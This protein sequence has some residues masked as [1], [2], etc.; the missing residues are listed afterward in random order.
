MRISKIILFF[1]SIVCM[2]FVASENYELKYPS[3]FPKPVYNFKNNE[4]TQSKI[5]LGRALFYDN[6]LSKNN[7][8]SCASCHSNYNAFSH[9]DHTLSHGIYDSIGKR[10]A[11]ALMNLAW[12]KNFMWDGAINHLDMQALAPL[13]SKIEMD[14]NINDVITKLSNS[15]IYPSLFYKAYHDSI[16]TGEHFLKSISAFMLSIVSFQSRYDS[17]RQGKILFNTQEKNGY[18]IFKKNCNSCHTEPLF[19][20]NLYECNGLNID[21]FLQDYGRVLITKNINDTCKFKVPT[22]RNIE[23]T[24]PYM[25]D[26]RYKSLQQVLTHYTHIDTNNS[27]TSIILKNKIQLSSNEKVD[28]ISFLLTLSDRAF[29]FNPAYAFPRKILLPSAK[30]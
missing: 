12:Q 20:N 6:I 30:D 16:I 28:L 11:P 18:I 25:H 3:Y 26:G 9:T 29:L 7:T 5:N 14:E 27:Y 22:L 1:I 4:L 15:K 21:T 17:M 23:Y 13:H 24:F 10:N 8:I 19:T 2:A